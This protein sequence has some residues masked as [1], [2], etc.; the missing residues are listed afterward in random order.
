M[1]LAIDVGN[2][3]TTIGLFRGGS[4]VTTFRYQ[5]RI[6]ETADEM[7]AALKGFLEL[8]GVQLSELDG[9]CLSSVVPRLTSSYEEMAARYLG[10][11][12]VVV[13]PGVRT[14]V[15]ILYDN[16]HEVG[17]D[18]I[19]N[20][21]ACTNLYGAPGIV[22]DFGTATTLD[23]VTERGEYLGGTISPGIMVSSEALFSRAAR[24]SKVDL[25]APRSTIGRNTRE[26][27][28]SGIVFG[29]AAMVDGLVERV[30]AELGAK[31]VVVA[32][33]GLSEIFR[34]I[35]RTIEVFDP[36]LTLKGLQI[37]FEKNA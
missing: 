11:R 24:L 35:S 37:I 20:A 33:G 26:S 36:H 1:L 32:T 14:G 19:T 23:V 25:V 16:P 17:A 31:P 4:L 8:A 15:P 34:G 29:T 27:L 6:F 10:A 21:V 7:A 30:I 12:T 2:T 18:R 5:T 22:V 28:Q 13:G 9:V 3:E